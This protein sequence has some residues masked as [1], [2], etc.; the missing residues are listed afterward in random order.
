[1]ELSF[2]DTINKLRKSFNKL[3]KKIKILII[4]SA[5]FLIL[6]ATG[7]TLWLNNE[8]YVVLFRGLSD[9]E[10]A[11]ILNK[12][13]SMSVD[14]K[15]NDDGTILVPKEDEARLK[16]TMAA[17]GY[18]ES[19]LNYDIFANSSDFM[20][21]DY[22]KQ[23][24]LIFQLQNRLQDAIKTIQG[25]KNA[26]VTI[27]LSDESSFVLK[28]DKVPTT[29]S[30]VLDL[31]GTTTLDKKQVKGI[32][33][34]VA[35]S[36]PGLD[37][38]NVVIIDG[39]GIILNDVND[40]NN[41]DAAYVK[42]ELSDK[43]NALYKEK[44]IELFKPILGEDGISVAVNSIIDFDKKVSEETTFSPII[45]EHGIISKQEYTK[46]STNGGTVPGGAPGTSTNVPVYQ[47]TTDTGTDISANETASTEYLVNQLIKS[48]QNDGGEIKDMT[49][50]IMINNQNL[51]PQTLNEYR[52]VVANCVGIPVGKVVITTAKFIEE[53][54]VVP[55]PVVEK[56]LLIQFLEKYM[57]YIL[58][59]AGILFI[60]FILLV[61]LLLRSRKKR[62]AE[63]K[64]V[65]EYANKL[66]EDK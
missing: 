53:P 23:K 46:E 55:E 10:N 61:I 1:M 60:L 5:I 4:F 30:V 35:K 15:I 20:S 49:V 17:E 21:T 39:D 3:S 14:L 28:D 2:T 44:I 36:I 22:E 32:E 27:S 31:A 50:S 43:I 62:L 7:I 6:I 54:V 42:I 19:A 63:K 45:D 57:Y 18:P 48:I 65:R 51:T 47:Q 8:N 64:K 29:A 9:T 40:M 24:Y 58:A 13:E 56:D 25:V 66:K 37:S 41:I 34:L 38:N 26:I 11:E 59:G 52:Q 16:M 33:E 12:L